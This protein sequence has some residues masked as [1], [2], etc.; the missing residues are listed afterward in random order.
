MN[1]SQPHI[2][3][4]DARPDSELPLAMPAELWQRLEAH[5]RAIF[6]E[7]QTVLDR[8]RGETSIPAVEL[9]R[10]MEKS[11]DDLLPALRLLRALELI[12][13]GPGATI[14]LV[15]IPD[16]PLR[17]KGPDGKWRWMFVSRPL[18]DPGLADPSREPGPQ[19]RLAADLVFSDGMFTRYPEGGG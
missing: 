11:L 4:H 15:A 5:R 1:T 8:L 9:C 18:R 16:D 17:I 2:S 6:V 7:A 19:A 12:D 13:V 3:R 14:V 10:E